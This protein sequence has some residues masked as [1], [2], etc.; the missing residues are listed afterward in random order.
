MHERKFE[1]AIY[2]VVLLNLDLV[3]KLAITK[4]KFNSYRLVIIT[5]T[6]HESFIILSS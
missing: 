4:I 6:K 2:T 1:V 5:Y 3:Y